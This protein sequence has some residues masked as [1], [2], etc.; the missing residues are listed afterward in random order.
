MKST[1]NTQRRRAVSFTHS[2]WLT[3]TSYTADLWR[4]GENTPDL[5]WAHSNAIQWAS[6]C[7]SCCIS[8]QNGPPKRCETEFFSSPHRTSDSQEQLRDRGPS[9]AVCR[10]PTLSAHR[11]STVKNVDRVYVLDQGRVIESGPYHE[12]RHRT[13]KALGHYVPSG[14]RAPSARWWRCRVSDT[15]IPYPDEVRPNSAPEP[16]V[17]DLRKIAGGSCKLPEKWKYVDASDD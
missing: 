7:A 14:R 15:S 16:M 12:L 8:G 5:Y 6:E 11:L 2:M 10:P 13:L 1:S 4:Q 3:S 17:G 9:T